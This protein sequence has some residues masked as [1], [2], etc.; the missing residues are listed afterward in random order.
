MPLLK[1]SRQKF[2]R[3]HKDLRGALL[4]LDAFRILWIGL[5]AAFVRDTWNV[6]SHFPYHIGR[7]IEN[8]TM[9][10]KTLMFKLTG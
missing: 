6:E 3:E 7:V 9:F 1:I 8:M 4:L 2:H 5:V 10:W